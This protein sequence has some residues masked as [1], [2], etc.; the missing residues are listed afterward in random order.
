MHPSQPGSGGADYSCVFRE[1]FLPLLKRMK[2]DLVMVSAG[3][4]TLSD[5]PVG[6]MN[7]VPEDLGY[8]TALLLDAARSRLPW[9]WK[10]GT[11]RPTARQYRHIFRALQGS[12][13]RKE[14]GDPSRH[15]SEIVSKLRSLH[16]L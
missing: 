4:D 12:P 8:L 11:A 13:C 2:P 5:D 7:L 3:Q 14:S 16:H 10:G 15:T 6:G 9:Y 1:V